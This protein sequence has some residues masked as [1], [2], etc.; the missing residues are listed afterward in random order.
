M[1]D[2]C[3]EHS[4]FFKVKDSKSNIFPIQRGTGNCSSNGWQKQSNRTPTKKDGGSAAY[5]RYP[6]T[7][8]LTAAT[9]I[10]AIG[11]GVTAAAGTRLALQWILV[12]GFKLYSFQLPDQ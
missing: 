9:L 7:S 3:F 1:Q 8:F 5:A 12:K 11:A 2:A 4:D 10:Y 6:T